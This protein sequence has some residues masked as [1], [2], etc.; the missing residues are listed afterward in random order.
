MRSLIALIASSSLSILM[1]L[2]LIPF[3]IPKIPILLSL[4]STSTR[5]S[6]IFFNHLNNPIFLDLSSL[7]NPSVNTLP[8]G[9]YS[10][11]TFSTT[12]G[13]YPKSFLVKYSYLGKS[14]LE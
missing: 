8:I 11:F 6:S 7:T 1:P 13:L 4:S 9:E 10:N 5:L 3:I 2:S 12:S 14:P